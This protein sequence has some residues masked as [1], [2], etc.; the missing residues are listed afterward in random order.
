MIES[1]YLPLLWPLLFVPVIGKPLYDLMEPTM[2]ILVNLGYGNIE[3]GWNDGPAD[4]PTM[5]TP[6]SP[7]LDWSEVS[8]ALEKAAQDRLGCLHRRSDGPGD[9]RW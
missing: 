6:D 2:R 9:L 3:H 7:T 1:E 4:L 5:V 8:L